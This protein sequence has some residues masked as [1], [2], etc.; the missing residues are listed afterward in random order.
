MMKQTSP[1]NSSY[2][3]KLPS[4]ISLNSDMVGILRFLRHRVSS[5]TWGGATWHDQGFPHGTMGEGHMA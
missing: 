2:E 3:I 1:L 5:D 4:R